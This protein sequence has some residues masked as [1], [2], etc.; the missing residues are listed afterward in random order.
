VEL[1]VR[2][3]VGIVDYRV[4]A[5][6]LEHRAYMQFLGVHQEAA[7]P[8]FSDD[9]MDAFRH[10]RND[11]EWFAGPFLRRENAAVFREFARRSRDDPDQFRRL[12]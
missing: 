8:G 1:H 7:Y 11:L 5:S 6:E 12:P 9:P 2:R 10:L 3:T 4:G